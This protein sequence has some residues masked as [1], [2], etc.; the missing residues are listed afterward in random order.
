MPRR[1]P[2]QEVRSVLF[3][4][5]LFSF[6]V[7]HHPIVNLVCP[8]TLV[9]NACREEGLLGLLAATLHE[10]RFLLAALE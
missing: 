3:R 2:F 9:D 7:L 4:L 1:K 8:I 6:P 10:P 5:F